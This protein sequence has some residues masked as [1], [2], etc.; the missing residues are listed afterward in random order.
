M[1]ETHRAVHL[2][3]V[4]VCTAQDVV[5]CVGQASL[6]VSC[7]C[8]VAGALRRSHAEGR[9]PPNPKGWTSRSRRTSSSYLSRIPWSA[10]DSRLSIH[11]RDSVDRV[12]WPKPPAMRVSA[13]LNASAASES[14]TAGG[15][16]AFSHSSAGAE[17]FE[18]ASSKFRW[19]PSPL[20]PLSKELNVQ[21]RH[22][23]WLG[24]SSGFK[25]VDARQHKPVR[26]HP[27]NHLS[28]FE[29]SD[30]PAIPKTVLPQAM[31]AQLDLVV[32]ER[33][34][35]CRSGLGEVHNRDREDTSGRPG[36]KG[37]AEQASKS[38]EICYAILEN[39]S[40]RPEQE[41]HAHR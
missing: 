35:L 5:L 8:F 24:Q 30:H 20:L 6:P 32:N 36:R 34:V 19:N 23:G 4:Y 38:D 40:D 7:G 11:P 16:E 13:L 31:L 18:N 37:S 15:L 14:T 28:S 41:L 3:T 29:V 10:A 17:R 39:T 26:E 25:R 27:L 1:N 2:C 21:R 33:I 12:A 9:Q 22:P